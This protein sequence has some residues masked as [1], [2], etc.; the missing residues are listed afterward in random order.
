VYTAKTT[1]QSLMPDMINMF[2]SVI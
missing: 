2:S 1:F